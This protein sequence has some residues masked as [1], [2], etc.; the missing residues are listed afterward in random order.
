[1]GVFFFSL[2]FICLFLNQFYIQDYFS[3]YEMDHSD[4]GAK[5]GGPQE[6][7]PGTP[8]SRTWLVSRAHDAGLE[9]ASIKAVR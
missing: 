6:K 1:M 4:D 3:S 5:M 9:P 2:L 8:T 7:P